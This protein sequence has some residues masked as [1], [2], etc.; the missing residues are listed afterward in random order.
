MGPQLYALL[1]WPVGH[2]VSPVMMNAA[3]AETAKSAHYMAFAVPPQALSQAIRGL[4]A[5]GAGGANIT[6]PHKQTV[7]PWLDEVSPIARLVGAVNTLRFSPQ[8]GKVVG[9]NTDVDGW[10]H[11]VAP[12]LSMPVR[13][14]LVLG[15]GG[16]A[17]AVIAALSLYAPDASVMVCSRRQVQADLLQQ[18]FDKV[19][20]VMI[21]WHLR[22]EAVKGVHMVINTTPLGMW[23]SV[24]SSPLGDQNCLAPGQIVY[25]LVYRPQNTLLL[26]QAR[27]SGAVAVSGLSMLVEQGAL[28]YEYWFSET[29]PRDL[30]SRFAQGAL[31]QSPGDK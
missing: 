31:A 22:C 29:A 24:G 28:A 6:I 19:P 18:N 17:R 7:L 20:L 23:P 15:A 21:P 16:A 10:W 2:S 27:Q 4:A 30:M 12:Y 8:T 14:V 26:Q 9:H 13:E 25:D 11:S 3:F 5:M 1:G